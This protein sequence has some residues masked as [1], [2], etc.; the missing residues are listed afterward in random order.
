MHTEKIEEL[1]L[2]RM[3]PVLE[4][5]SFS[6]VVRICFLEQNLGFVIAYQLRT[7]V[8]GFKDNM[9][10]ET[11]VTTQHTSNWLLELLPHHRTIGA[12]DGTNCDSCKGKVSYSNH[13]TFSKLYT[14]GYITL[15]QLRVRVFPLLYLKARRSSTSCSKNLAE[16][17]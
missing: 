15:I 6:V 13:Q 17:S 16:I 8:R 1:W 3:H 2:A 11:T 9:P 5:R 14:S 12:D 4:H 10:R 7:A